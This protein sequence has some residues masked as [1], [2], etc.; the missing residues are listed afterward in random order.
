MNDTFFFFVCIKKPFNG[1][2]SVRLLDNIAHDIAKYSQFV[3]FNYVS[4]Q[5]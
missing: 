1:S 4:I 2:L 3:S 5:S